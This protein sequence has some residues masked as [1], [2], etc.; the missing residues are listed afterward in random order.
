MSNNSLYNRIISY[1]S[2]DDKA[3][4]KFIELEKAF[5]DYSS[6]VASNDLKKAPKEEVIKY[7]NLLEEAASAFNQS[8]SK[9]GLAIPEKASEISDLF[10]NCFSNRSH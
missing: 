2:K 3:N 7:G 10:I 9:V 8:V 5:K 1:V 6:A 4:E